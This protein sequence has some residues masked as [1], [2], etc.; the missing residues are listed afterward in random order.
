MD[1]LGLVIIVS[2]FASVI[3][4][5]ER[6]EIQVNESRLDRKQSAAMDTPIALT[7]SNQS[8]KFELI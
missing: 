6:P 5:A 7:T 4:M 8:F 3:R 2:Y 1:V